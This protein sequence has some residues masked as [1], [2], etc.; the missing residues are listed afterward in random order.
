MNN[1]YSVVQ[2]FTDGDY[3][4][5]RRNVEKEEAVKA[6]HHYSNSVAVRMGFVARVIITDYLDCVVIEWTAEKGLTT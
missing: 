5:V 3:E 2:F 1:S 4:Y 6:F